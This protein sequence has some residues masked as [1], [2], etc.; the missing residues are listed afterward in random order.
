MPR[1]D[2]R[3][4]F[5]KD[6]E[7]D[8][9]IAQSTFRDSDIRDVSFGAVEADILEDIMARNSLTR[10]ALG[11]RSRRLLVGAG[12]VAALSVATVGGLLLVD[13][14]SGGVDV[15]D[16]AWN[17]V[18]FEPSREQVDALRVSCDGMIG[19]NWRDLDDGKE[20]SSSSFEDA[21]IV[22]DFRG[23]VGT[24]AYF[25]GNRVLVCMKRNDY[26]V[27]SPVELGLSSRLNPS[28]TALG[29]VVSF[30]ND[31]TGL[32][33]GNV[34]DDG[35][36]QWNVRIQEPETRDIMASVSASGRYVAW[37]NSIPHDQESLKVAFSSDSDPADIR[38]VRVTAVDPPIL[39][40]DSSTKDTQ[41]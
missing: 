1:R 5:M 10:G 22:T 6:E 37:I 2:E 9:L 16:A 40:F 31:L 34:P 39:T 11:T 3:T 19:G 25:R 18:P 35:A 14:S 8:R 13:T 41:P 24:V 23:E 4:E 28:G 29:L 20:L 21:V 32:V 30:D 17:P 27:L 38:S 33:V 36:D 26:L 12:A 15:A 7:L